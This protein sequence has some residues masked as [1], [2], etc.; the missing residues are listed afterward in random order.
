[1][2]ERM[3]STVQDATVYLI[4]DNESA[5]F[6]HRRVL[7]RVGHTGKVKAFTYAHKALETLDRHS[8]MPDLIFIDLNMPA[9]NGWE[10]IDA[11]ARRYSKLPPPQVVILTTSENP[12]DERRARQL[13][14]PVIF[15]H[16]PL[17]PEKFQDVLVP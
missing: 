4:D 10:F 17:T 12:D 13:G 5:N 2:A 3:N 8:T 15:L 16:K 1:M 6:L 9:M 14:H 7:R 11:L